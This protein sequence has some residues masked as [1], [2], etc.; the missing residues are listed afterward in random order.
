MHK[1]AFKKI[2]K[3]LLTTDDSVYLQREDQDWGG[4]QDGFYLNLIVS[5]I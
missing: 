2:Q 4:G 1:N 5:F 3:N